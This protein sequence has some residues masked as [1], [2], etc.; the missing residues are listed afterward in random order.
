M[1]GGGK[2]VLRDIPELILDQRQASSR[3]H[4]GGEI[5]PWAVFDQRKTQVVPY[6]LFVDRNVPGAGGWLT[7]HCI[8]YP[9]APFPVSG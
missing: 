7:E 2:L 1:S 4:G 8:R 9:F 5:S 3:V 6:A